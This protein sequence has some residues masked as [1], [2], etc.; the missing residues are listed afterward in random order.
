MIQLTKY[1]LLLT[2]RYAI[3]LIKLKVIHLINLIHFL[4]IFNN[5]TRMGILRTS[6]IT[7]AI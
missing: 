4:S 5:N 2:G 1:Y 3:T 6:S 7:R